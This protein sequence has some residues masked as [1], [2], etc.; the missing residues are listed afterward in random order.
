MDFDQHMILDATRGSIARFIN[1]SCEPNCK[2]IKWTV[3]GKPRMAL[4]AGEQGIMTGEELTYDYNFNPY[5]VKNVQQCRCGALSCRGVL[6]PKP[7]EKEI[8]DALKPLTT[9][10]KRKF[11]KTIEDAFKV[12]TKKRKIAIASSAM[13]AVTK[14]S[15]KL[16][17]S[18]ILASSTSSN[19]RQ[20]AVKKVITKS[21]TRTR[22]VRRAANQVRKNATAVYARGRSSARA[23]TKEKPPQDKRPQNKQEVPTAEAASSVKQNPMRTTKGRLGLST[24]ASVGRG[25]K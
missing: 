22:I 15:R 12:V 16:S 23:V 1:H 10:N 13:N 14:A 21:V 6:G 17:K 3:A 7:K 18:R 20:R 4:F 2:M 5:S 9:G 8:K 11:Q 25:S 19:Q 24:R